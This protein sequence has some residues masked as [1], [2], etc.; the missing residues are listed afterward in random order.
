[1]PDDAK[2]KLAGMIALKQDSVV[3]SP[4]KPAKPKAPP[5][6]K[7]IDKISAAKGKV[8]RVQGSGSVKS[9]ASS[10]PP[11]SLSPTPATPSA[12]HKAKVKKK[13]V[14]VK[15]KKVKRPKKPPGPGILTLVMGKFSSYVQE[16]VQEIKQELKAKNLFKPIKEGFGSMLKGASHVK[17][18]ISGDISLDDDTLAIPK[19]TQRSA[20][21]GGPIRPKQDEELQTVVDEQK[22]TEELG[23]AFEKLGSMRQRDSHKT[24]AAEIAEAEVAAETPELE[25][26]TT[27]SEEVPSPAGPGEAVPLV[28]DPGGGSI[29]E[30]Q[31][32]DSVPL[33][34]T[35]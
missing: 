9:A 26:S 18:Q 4:P 3:K 14:K 27:S 25:P 35:T 1:M 20:G 19:G 15:K 34:Q 11:R 16:E 17:K 30:P 22:Q 32:A 6:P 13:K 21:S 10:A 31:S 23:S 7:P 2:N 29:G 8:T 28:D 24:P 5:P 12:P 33:A